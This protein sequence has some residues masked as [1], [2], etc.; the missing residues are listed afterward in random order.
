MSDQR[1]V[2]VTGATGA[3]GGAVCAALLAA[4]QRVRGYVRN[5]GSAAARRLRAGGAELAVGAFDDARALAQALDGA[6]AAYVMGTPWEE[7]TAGEQRQVRSVLA[8]CQA[9]GVGHVIYSSCANA[10]RGTGIAWY[11]AKFELERDL[12][13]GRYGFDWTIVGPAVFMQILRAPHAL[14]G[15][16]SGVLAMALPEAHVQTWI[17]VRDIGSFAAHVVGHPAPWL[18]QRVDLASERVAGT[19]VTRML[20]QASGRPIRYQQV[21]LETIAQFNKDIA[22]MYEWFD[23]VGMSVD[24]EALHARTPE[25]AWT[26]FREWAGREDW[27]VLDHPPA[28]AWS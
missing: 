26:T 15:L 28:T 16:A 24:V 5:P 8:A 27:S 2:L 20:S 14:T 13:Q 22:E 25:V 19:D 6:D 9:S 21:P 4:G 17:D 7:G 3:Q 18:G 23:R 1:T 11:E 10:D 12:V